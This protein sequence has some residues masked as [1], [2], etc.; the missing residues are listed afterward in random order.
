MARRLDSRLIVLD[1]LPGSGKTTTGRWL[2]VQLQQHGL[3]PR[4]LPEADIAHPLW[5]YQHW[6]GTAYEPPD[7]QNTPTEVFIEASIRKWKDFVGQ[8]QTSVQLHVAESVFFQN[9]VAMF[10]MGGARSTTLVEYAQ[11]VQAITQSLNPILIYVRQ[12]DVVDALE[13]I[14]TLRGP[15]FEQELI[16]NMEQFPYRN[17][18]KLKGLGGVA[19]LWSEI[20][21][22]T[23]ALFESYTIRKLAI[24]TSG[25]NWQ[26]YQQQ[27][28]DF[29]DLPA[30]R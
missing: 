9:A 12:N 30:Q 27:I 23:D 6:N 25:R 10:L 13:K 22:I 1:G 21:E 8:A 26:A 7:F 5:W 14:C 28:L 18:R 4:W 24:E 15:A 11:E 3:N 20:N 16:R 17:Q 2:T 29:L 19:A